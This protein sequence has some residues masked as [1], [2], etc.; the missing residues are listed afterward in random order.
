MKRPIFGRK[1]GIVVCH[2]T[3]IASLAPLNMVENN[4]F[5]Q[6]GLFDVCEINMNT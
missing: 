3:V 2:K 1:F 6:V 5:A 4:Y